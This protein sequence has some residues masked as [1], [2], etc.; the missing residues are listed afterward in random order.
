MSE[1]KGSVRQLPP[2]KLNN[3]K[4]IFEDGEGSSA[5]KSD[6]SMPPARPLQ[7]PSRAKSPVQQ[8]PP[9]LQP[10]SQQHSKF[11]AAN[12]QQQQATSAVQATEHVV[13]NRDQNFVSGHKLCDAGRFTSSHS[14]ASE[15]TQQGK[16][17]K[18]LNPSVIGKFSAPSD[19]NPTPQ[20]LI[21]DK[22]TSAASTPKP[23]FRHSRESSAGGETVIVDNPLYTSVQLPAKTAQEISDLYAKVNK[24]KKDAD[25]LPRKVSFTPEDKEAAGFSR[26]EAIRKNAVERRK[27]IAGGETEGEEVGGN[28]VNVAER[29]KLFDV[30]KGAKPTLP[31]KP[32]SVKRKFSMRTQKEFDEQQQHRSQVFSQNDSED[33]GVYSPPWDTSKSSILEKL[34]KSKPSPAVLLEKSDSPGFTGKLGAATKTPGPGMVLKHPDISTPKLTAKV[35]E[36][37]VLRNQPKSKSAESSS[38]SSPQRAAASAPPKPPRTHAHDDYL[39][40]K[41]SVS[42]NFDMKPSTDT[43]HQTNVRKTVNIITSP[44]KAE[45]HRETEYTSIKDRITKLQQHSETSSS[46]SDPPLLPPVSF[47]EKNNEQNTVR[48]PAPSRPPPPR[49]RPNSDDRPSISSTFSQSST[50]DDIGPV[51]IPVSPQARIPQQKQV[52][53]TPGLNTRRPSDKLPPEPDPSK[54]VQKFPLRKSYSSECLHSSRGSSLN[55]E[56][57]DE[58]SANGMSRSSYESQYEAVIDP[59]GYA[60]PNVFL[61]LPG[62]KKLSI[63]DDN[64]DVSPTQF[65]T[66]IKGFSGDSLSDKSQQAQGIKAVS[67]QEQSLEKVNKK[68]MNMV[69]Q[70]INQAYADVDFTVGGPSERGD[71]D[72]QIVNQ[73]Q[74]EI[75]A[76][77]T[78]YAGEAVVEPTVLKKRIEYCTSVRLKSSKSIRHCKEYLSAVYPQLFEYCLIVGL[79]RLVDVDGYE[80]HVKFK[81]PENV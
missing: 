37:V 14:L 71:S 78:A 66:R 21:S 33:G 39:R 23:A 12:Q 55:G 26:R 69:K 6:K 81:F 36:N 60:V 43:S 52:P 70:K 79:Q 20:N 38:E 73:E 4:K 54:S 24:P 3:I 25:G 75:F 59:D 29:M 30:T 49:R 35:E 42:Q 63:K 58:D 76:D 17:V 28:S 2:G 45:A 22:G 32:D 8:H 7:P 13:Q 65:L 77:I 47:T 72:W 56:W 80:P 74:G 50:E 51:I 5:S 15:L 16:D 46:S 41:V 53:N 18:K 34:Q 31:Q 11:L 64:L 19:N 68:K 44:E 67:V 40:V 48:T 27:T 62:Q 9:R 1:Q 61:R 57:G 10:Q